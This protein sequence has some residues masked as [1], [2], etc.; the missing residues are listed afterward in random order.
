MSETAHSRLDSIGTE[1]GADGPGAQVGDEVATRATVDA[2]RALIDALRVADA[3]SAT[4]ARATQLIGEATALLDE[5]RVEALRMQGALRPE[6]MAG[7]LAADQVDLDGAS[8]D[9]PADYFPYSPI[10]GPLNPLAPP[11]TVTWDGERLRG[12]ATFG[13]PYVGPPEM[14]HGGV[15]ALLFD[16]VLGATNLSAGLG[17]FTGTLTIRYERPTP[18]LAEVELECRIEK[19]EGRK[20]TTVGTITHDGH[21]T[22]RASGVFIR[23]VA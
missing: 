6:R 22:A 8:P 16:E 9:D 4:L 18:L 14:V 11:A 3:P 1:R 19:V 17:G 2:T 21:V 20:V 13:A 23:S 7:L 15:I 5:H 10:I 12:T